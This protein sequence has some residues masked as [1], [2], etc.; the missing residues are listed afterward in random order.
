MGQDRHRLGLAEHRLP[1]GRTLPAIDEARELL[2]DARGDARPHR[3][4]WTKPWKS[5]VP[6][7]VPHSFVTNSHSS[8][9]QHRTSM[10]EGLR[11]T[12]FDKN[13]LSCGSTLLSSRLPRTFGSGRFARIE[14]S[15]R[16][17]PRMNNL[18][19]RAPSPLVSSGRGSPAS[20]AWISSRER[21]F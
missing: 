12:N 18:R 13:R 17:V 14:A 7:Y 1:R 6:M 9:D 21:P 11:S 4:L 20:S 3:V 10:P 15:R 5:P 8:F 2:A 19:A 16:A